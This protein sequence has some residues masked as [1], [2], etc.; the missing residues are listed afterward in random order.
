MHKQSIPNWIEN[1]TRVLHRMVHLTLLMVKNSSV[2]GVYI[3]DTCV[4][5][6]DNRF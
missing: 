5:C 4:V 2:Y 6:N 1:R 3:D